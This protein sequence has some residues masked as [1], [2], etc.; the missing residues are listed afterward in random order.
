[1]GADGSQFLYELV[2]SDEPVEDWSEMISISFASTG[3]SVDE[4]VENFKVGLRSTDPSAQV[5][6]DDVLD[7]KSRMVTYA[8]SIEEGVMRFILG[9]D[10]LHM[11]A[12]MVKPEA[13]T[14][15]G[16][17]G[18]RGCFG[19]KVVQHAGLKPRRRPDT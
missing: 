4:A 1:M 16:W 3:V 2:R 9:S 11:V 13:K 15:T 12:Y 10:G 14:D 8:T 19:G 7:D 6:G 17:S 18:G 5:P